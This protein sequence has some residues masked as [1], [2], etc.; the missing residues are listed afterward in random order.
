MNSLGVQPAHKW[1][2]QDAAVDAYDASPGAEG[3]RG[4]E[5]LAYW[6]ASLTKSLAPA[7]ERPSL[8]R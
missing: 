5:G 4:S 6:P 1:K 7:S 2:H 8:R 3:T